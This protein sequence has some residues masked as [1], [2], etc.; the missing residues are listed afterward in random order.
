MKPYTKRPGTITKS[1]G[2]YTSSFN[3]PGPGVLSKDFR[4]KDEAIDFL[5]KHKRL[6]WPV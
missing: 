6:V 1:S 3:V 5:K 2:W 4:S